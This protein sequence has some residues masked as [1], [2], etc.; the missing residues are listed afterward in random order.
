MHGLA[1]PEGPKM[2]EARYT[3][4]GGPEVERRIAG[5][6]AE[7]AEAVQRVVPQQRLRS[8]V[9]M[10]GYGRGEGGV[11]VR[12]GVEH[13]HNN[14][15]LLVITR[16]AAPP[17]LKSHLDDALAPISNR[18]GIGTD[19]GVIADHALSRAPCLVMWYDLRFGHRTLLGDADFVPSLDRFRVDRIERAD[20]RD[21]LVNRGTLLLINDALI[22]QGP[23]DP[24]QRRVVVRHAMK[25]IIG[26]GDA[27]LFFHGDYH[28]SYGERRRRMAARRDAPPALRALYEQAMAFR[29]RPD[30]L[31]FLGRD[32]A[33]WMEDLRSVLAPVHLC[34]EAMR[35]SRP[36]L[37]W[38]E[39]ARASLWRALREGLTDPLSW[40]RRGRSLLGGGLRVLSPWDVGVLWLIAPPR[41]RLSVLFPT[42]AYGLEEPVGRA[43]ARTVLGWDPI[44]QRD[45]ARLAFLRWWGRH[46]DPNFEAAARRMGLRL[47][48]D[49]A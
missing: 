27:W 28:W 24:A 34:V 32:L 35:L 16:G 1:A 26:Y 33:V 44:P 21:L 42:V 8:L 12:D 31:A 39:H 19:V 23:L 13:P 30:H 17:A 9:L 7:V 2:P 47:Q 10:G 11:E 36:H 3:M 45:A 37:T 46:G 4:D 48:G 18:H 43:L 22:A 6:L 38:G 15:D 25:A 41:E 5:I 40:A 49:K 20:V 14:L 29:F